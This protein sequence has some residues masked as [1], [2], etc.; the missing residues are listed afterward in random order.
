VARDLAGKPIAVFPDHAPDRHLYR[1]RLFSA[2]ENRRAPIAAG[3]LATASGIGQLL[4]S[5]V[6]AATRSG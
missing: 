2:K 6:G 5:A 4:P 1:H 3:G